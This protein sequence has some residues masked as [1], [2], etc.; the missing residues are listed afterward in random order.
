MELTKRGQRR[1]LGKDAGETALLNTGRQR[2]GVP[3]GRVQGRCGGRSVQAGVYRSVPGRRRWEG[4]KAGSRKAGRNL[5]WAGLE[6]NCRLA[7]DWL[8]TLWELL[9][10]S[11]DAGDSGLETGDKPALGQALA[12][13]LEKRAV[14]RGRGWAPGTAAASQ[15]FRAA[16]RRR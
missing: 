6:T 8:E 14:A 12:G 2:G 7:R 1:G 13:N 11:L 5:G 10:W 16:E 4:R 3:G 9:D 15:W